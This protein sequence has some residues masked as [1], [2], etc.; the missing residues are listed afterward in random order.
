[1]S[2]PP[3][4]PKTTKDNPAAIFISLIVLTLLGLT[5]AFTQASPRTVTPQTN[6]RNQSPADF[7]EHT[8]NLVNFASQVFLSQAKTQITVP[9]QYPEQPPVL[10]LVYP[11]NVGTALAFLI[12]H[13]QLNSLDWPSTRSG[14]FT[15]YQRQ[16]TYSTLEDFLA[17]PPDLDRVLADAQAQHDFPELQ[18]TTGLNHPVNLDDYDFIVTNFTLPEYD[19]GAYYSTLVIDAS[20]AQV[21]DQNQIIWAIRA[22]D[23]SEANPYRLGNIHV[24]YL[25]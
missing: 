16:P 10:Y 22:P 13:P 11:T 14:A 3:N 12:S 21:N 18:D 5:A 1:M 2:P 17:N 9:F 25:Q 20:N 24:D 19:N 23:A 7:N 8:E 6:P 15:L 4:R